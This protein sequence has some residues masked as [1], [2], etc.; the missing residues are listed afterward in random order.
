MQL[1]SSSRNSSV[2]LRSESDSGFDKEDKNANG[3]RDCE[4]I[5]ERREYE[6][7]L[8]TATRA[9]KKPNLFAKQLANL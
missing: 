8:R 1:I 7:L 6:V 4:Q 2:S 5:E 3:S 9:I